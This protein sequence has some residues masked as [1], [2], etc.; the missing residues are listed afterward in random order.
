MATEP[1]QPQEADKLARDVTLVNKHGIH[2]RTAALISELTER[3]E[4][5]IIITSPSASSDA[6]DMMRLLLLQA[7][8]GTELNISVTGCDAQAALGAICSL[9]ENGFELEDEKVSDS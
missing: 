4:S 1:G 8:Y 6:S 7:G 5:N 3:Y 2:V 9:I